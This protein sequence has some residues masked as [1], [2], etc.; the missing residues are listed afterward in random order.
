M[1]TATEAAGRIES[2]WGLNSLQNSW[3]DGDEVPGL[4]NEVARLWPQKNAIATSL[5]ISPAFKVMRIIYIHVQGTE[6]RYITPYSAWYHTMG[7]RGGAVSY[8]EPEPA[9]LAEMT[10]FA[11]AVG[12]AAT[13]AASAEHRLRM[14]LMLSSNARLNERY[15]YRIIAA[16]GYPH[17]KNG[18]IT[19]YWCSVAADPNP[20]CPGCRRAITDGGGCGHERTLKVDSFYNGSIVTCP[21]AKR[22]TKTN[23]GA[24]TM[25]FLFGTETP[26]LPRQ[27]TRW[28]QPPAATPSD[29]PQA[30]FRPY[31]GE[32]PDNLDTK[33]GAQ[34]EEHIAQEPWV[35]PNATFAPHDLTVVSYNTDN[36]AKDRLAELISFLEEVSADVVLLQDTKNQRWSHAALLRKGWVIYTHNSVCI[37][38]RT[39][40]AERVISCTD[41]TGTPRARVWRSQ[42]Y[43]SMGIVLDTTKG[44]LFIAC[45]YLPHGVDSLPADP[46]DSRRKAVLDQ[47]TE[48]SCRAQGHAYAII[49]MDANETTYTRGRVQTHADGPS[50][51]SGC[52]HNGGLAASAMGIYATHMTDGQR[53]FKSPNHSY[54]HPYPGLDSMTFTGPGRSDSDIIRVQSDIDYI[55]CSTSLAGRMVHFE[56]DPRTRTWCAD[57]KVR[58]SFHSALVTTFQWSDMWLSDTTPPPPKGAAL[59]GSTLKLGPNYAALTPDKAKAIAKRFNLSLHSR[60]KR[61]KACWKG[62]KSAKVKRDTLTNDFKAELLRV[63]KSILGV[64]KPQSHKCKGGLSSGL[65]QVWANLVKLVGNALKVTIMGYSSTQQAD[66]HGVEMASIRTTLSASGIT[67]PVGDDEWLHWWHRR[68]YHHAEA[69]MNR[70]ALTLTDK[71]ATQ[72]PKRFFAQVTKPLASAQISSLRRGRKVITTDEGIEEELH[73]FLERVAAPGKEQSSDR[74]DGRADR[75]GEGTK[76]RKLYQTKAWGLLDTITMDELQKCLQQLDSTS[77]AGYDGISPAILK[78]VTMT[79]W[80]QE[81]PK[82]DVD[83]QSDELHARFDQYCAQHRN[84]DMGYEGDRP[85]PIAPPRIS[86]TTKVVYEPNLARQLLLRILNLCL[87]SG[88]VPRVEKLGI[89]TALP[90]SE[91]LVSNTD[92]MRPITVG[93]A[94]NRLVHKILADRLSTTLVKNSLLDKAQFAFIPGGDTHE[95]I[96]A[97]AACYR[98]RKEHDKGCFAIYYDISKAYDNI[99]WS[100][101]KTAMLEIG[102]D[103]KFINFVMTAL[104]GSRVAMRTNVPGNVTREVELHKSIK[105]GCPL[106]PLLF[107]IVMDELHRNLRAANRGYKFGPAGKESKLEINSRGYCDDTYIVTSTIDDLRYLNENVVY[108]FFIKHGLTI[109]SKKTKVTGRWPGPNGT[110]FEGE[111]HWPGSV[112]PF[113]TVPPDKAVKYLGAHISLDL[114][115]T[116]QINKMR[117]HLMQALTH[118]RSGRLTTLQGV[119]IAKYV[120]GPQMEIGMRHAD[121]PLQ[122]LREWDQWLSSAIT[123]RAGLG[124]ASLHVSSV[125]TVC[126]LTPMEDQY[127]LSKLAHVLEVVTR[128]ST[129]KLYYGEIVQPLIGAISRVM[130]KSEM[131]LPSEADLPSAASV[132]HAWPEITAALLAAA[133]KGLWIEFNTKSRVDGVEKVDQ[134]AAGDVTDTGAI[135]F[136]NLR[137][138]GVSIPTRATHHLWGSSFDKTRALGPLLSAGTAPP[139]LLEIAARECV[140]T[141][142]TYH[143]PDCQIRQSILHSPSTIGSVMQEAGPMRRADCQTCKGI[144]GSF[145]EEISSLVQV[146]AATDGSTYTGRHSGAALVYMA[147][148]TEDDELW[149]QGYGWIIG[150]ENNYI[151]ELSAIHRAIRSIPVN[152]DITIHTDS[153]SSID[154]VLSALRCPERV[155]FL[156]KGGR[157]YVMAICRAWNARLAAG[158]VT[159]LKHVRAHTGGRSKAA[160]GNACADRVAKYYALSENKDDIDDKKT[161]LD[162]MEADLKF[163][164]HTRSPIPGGGSDPEGVVFESSPVHGDVREA[165]RKTLRRIR[166]EEWAD[167]RARPKRGRLVRDHPAE[168]HSAI[169]H[170]RSVANSSTTLSLLLSGLNTV[171]EKDFSAGRTDKL[172]GRCGTGSSLTATHKCHS[173]PCNTQ[174]LNDRD[175]QLAVL[176]GYANDMAEGGP[177]PTALMG[178]VV[179]RRR[180]MVKNLSSST[181]TTGI[182]VVTRTI[183]FPPSPSMARTVRLDAFE[184]L[185]QY[186][187]M[188]NLTANSKAHEGALGAEALDQLV[189]TKSPAVSDHLVWLVADLGGRHPR[190]QS[191]PLRQLCRWVLRTYSDLYLNPLTATAPWN[192]TWYS[193]HPDGWKVGGTTAASPLCFLTNRYTWI[194]MRSGASSQIEDL[195]M[196][197]QAAKESNQPCRVALLVHHSDQIK[198]MISTT[199]S[200]VRKHVL[201]TIGADASTLFSLDDAEFPGQHEARPLYSSPTPVLLLVIENASAPGYDLCHIRAALEG[202]RGVEI[203]PSEYKYVSCPPDTTTPC[204]AREIQDRHH[205]LLRS[206][207]T[208]CR[209]AHHYTPPPHACDAKAPELGRIPDRRSAG[210]RL[211]PVLGLLGVNPKG[212]GPDIASHSGV[213]PTPLGIVKQLSSLVLNTSVTAYRRSEAYGRW[214]RKT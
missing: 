43:N 109:N 69:L 10:V 186:A 37:L 205:P 115:W 53:H 93:P 27:P 132:Q 35:D 114:I 38:L 21:G 170:A 155:N 196:A 99:R 156:R 20:V 98:D 82:T 174:L 200:G 185:H 179:Q 210:D 161:A 91:G 165:A 127:L 148:D 59:K 191:P 177:S 128:T 211:N 145:D 168:V 48:I 154:S 117:G 64:A 129:L 178:Q 3:E 83:M 100:S 105:Q 199:T 4:S 159:T 189:Y 213:N 180:D 17:Q 2:T 44:P 12:S 212:L 41:S 67:L 103:N 73:S 136:P 40:T 202:E 162:L 18:K 8:I 33:A 51:Y 146:A 158:G 31:T 84:G 70:E 46:E 71:M 125:T 112:T 163:L 63:A 86:P 118:L 164:L 32:Q 206:S 214:R 187:L 11:N 121:V 60:W 198:D 176:T 192:D 120:T 113:E 124:S 30:R 75:A 52:A 201:A 126:T 50:T 92:D 28:V 171:T 107:I 74:S 56:V 79:T 139:K 157:P 80:E 172:C 207:Q 47:H 141:A 122:M 104:E 110:P 23:V 175:D 137:F 173:C 62:K 130:S 194:S 106:A 182:G 77:S 140:R 209:A 208:W 138:G 181:A 195:E 29:H 116:E 160:I 68:D 101:I 143:H 1:D 6:L 22:S 188:Y 147:D 193:R 144:W 97:A 42:K 39:S 34:P 65:D 102:L 36:C 78:I 203:H 7:H 88:D 111:V 167:E 72:D 190:T 153:Q 5:V 19:N 166:T 85:M 119:S 123:T 24:D 13:S 49:G 142:T 81:M 58:T 133:G 96:G 89:I 197:T 26:R 150:M 184:Q 152:V 14:Q 183:T 87:E 151:A 15:P 169:K 57:G 135:H 131:A 204:P 16:K 25:A 55:L 134:S 9:P 149:R 54:S 76:R 61:L 45:A 108:P 90:K 95:P 66:L 94:I